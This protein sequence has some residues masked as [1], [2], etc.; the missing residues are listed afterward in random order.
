[1]IDKTAEANKPIHIFG[2]RINAVLL[3]E[4]NRLSIQETL[5]LIFISEMGES[6]NN[7]IP[8]AFSNS[9]ISAFPIGMTS[10]IAFEAITDLAENSATSSLS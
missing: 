1:M 2:K 9:S 6:I 3:S 8:N 5:F 4:E 7:H 10:P